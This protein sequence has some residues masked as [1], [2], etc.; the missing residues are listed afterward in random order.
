ME[1]H[2]R[3]A[4]ADRASRAIERHLTD[5]HRNLFGERHLLGPRRWEGLWPFSSAWSSAARL[6]AVLPS[7]ATD[8]GRFI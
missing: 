7:R 4:R 5:R 6:A 8:P 2:D 3:L 1:D